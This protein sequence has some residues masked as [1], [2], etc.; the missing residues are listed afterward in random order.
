MK[1]KVVRLFHYTN[2]NSRK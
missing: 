2:N 1:M